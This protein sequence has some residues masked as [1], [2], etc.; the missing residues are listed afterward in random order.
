MIE[1]SG[2]EDPDSPCPRGHVPWG[3][4]ITIGLGAF[5]S[6]PFPLRTHDIGDTSHPRHILVT[7]VSTTTSLFVVVPCMYGYDEKGRTYLACM[8]HVS[9]PT[10]T[11]TDDLLSST[12]FSSYEVPQTHYDG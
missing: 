6:R 4:M 7:V 8:E 3:W 5:R 2:R 12:W 1:Y 11:E 9:P 10:M